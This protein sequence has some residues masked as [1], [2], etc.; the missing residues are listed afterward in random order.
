MCTY[1]ASL[2][3]GSDLL[4]EI[5]SDARTLNWFI[6][7]LSETSRSTAGGSLTGLPISP[8]DPECS[9]TV[10]AGSHVCSL[11]RGY[12]AES[13]MKNQLHTFMMLQI[14]NTFTSIISYSSWAWKKTYRFKICIPVIISINEI[15]L[16]IFTLYQR[17][18]RGPFR[19]SS[20]PA[21]GTPAV[22]VVEQQHH[23]D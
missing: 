6:L 7:N 4:R 10:G 13:W 5:A 18:C 11:F 3:S 20:T 19:T 15:N 2:T 23:I 21:T 16:I 17:V 8:G 9:P 12:C 22:G 14:I 1:P